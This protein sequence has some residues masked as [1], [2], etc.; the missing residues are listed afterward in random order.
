MDGSLPKVRCF[1]CLEPDLSVRRNLERWIE[2]LKLQAPRLRW[3]R[4]GALHLTLKFCGEISVE[5]LELFSERLGTEIS[6]SGP[7]SLGF[8]KNGFFSRNGVPSVL[9]GG[10]TGD[11]VALGSL[12][13]KVEQASS[14]IG[15]PRER[16]SFSPHLTLARI[17]AAGDLPR[18]WIQAGP[19]GNPVW[20]T[21]EVREVTLMESELRSEGP[22]YRPVKK[23][24]LLKSQ[25]GGK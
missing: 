6:G 1:V 15:I 19:P 23:F 4:P 3:V 25:G 11:T 17:R 14:S 22:I 13:G 18:S 24:S 16:R 21:W 7:F 2:P 5:R 9:W 8:E 12:F 10:V 20:G